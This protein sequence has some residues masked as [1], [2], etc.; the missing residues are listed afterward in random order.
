M[1]EY[2][3]QIIDLMPLPQ[4]H[5]EYAQQQIGRVVESTLSQIV[6]TAY[7]LQKPSNQ[8]WEKNSTQKLDKLP[9]KAM[10]ACQGA[11]GSYQ[12]IACERFFQ[13]PD[14]VFCD[15]FEDVTRCVAEGDVEF[16]VLP[17]QNS[18]AGEVEDVME[19]ICR[20][21]CYIVSMLPVPA[22]H[23][24]CVKKG[25]TREEI[26]S[27]YS[28]PQAL[29]Q[30]AGFLEK[31]NWKPLRCSNTAVAAQMVSKSEAKACLCSVKSAQIYDLEVLEYAVQDRKD[32]YTRFACIANKAIFL[33]EASVV[34]VALSF[35]NHPDSLRSLLTHFSLF[36]L[37]LTKIQSMPLGGA[38]FSVRFHLD[39]TGNVE[40]P[41]I[42]NLLGHLYDEYED[43]QFL[44]NFPLLK[45]V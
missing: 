27:V 3:S 8:L 24:L 26:D 45:L 5:S 33:P 32:N 4:P 20:H 6:D 25:T 10:V 21:H 41:E 38:D 18:T 44:G 19:F 31:N 16:G 40:Q 23:C 15:A 28:H 36:G 9:T 35:P 42:S 29:R 13:Q 37:D 7:L 39:F 1:K 2:W 43:F 34:S 12:Q 11:E 22:D 17:V 30:S 14:I